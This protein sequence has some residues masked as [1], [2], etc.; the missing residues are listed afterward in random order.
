MEYPTL[1]NQS[2]RIPTTRPL[3]DSSPLRKSFSRRQRLAR[4]ERGITL[5]TLIVTAVLVLVAVAAGVILVA[6]SRSQESSLTDSGKSDPGEGTCEPWEINDIELKAKQLG[7][8][9]GY[10]GFYSS[11]V[12]CVRVCYV[13]AV[14]G[15]ATRMDDDYRLLPSDQTHE[16]SDTVYQL[17]LGFSFSDQRIRPADVPAANGLFPTW[18]VVSSTQVGDLPAPTTETMRSAVRNVDAA[19][20]PLRSVLDENQEIRVHPS[21]EFCHAVDT[22]NDDEEITRSDALII[23]R[24]T[25]NRFFYDQ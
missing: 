6:I 13:Q 5:Q 10:G 21:Q 16:Y 24:S 3:P 4:D 11:A 12:G 18:Q 1:G 25:H 2:N 23:G 14:S 9:Q 22:A 20:Q 7:G 15:R 19:E 17:V 8:P